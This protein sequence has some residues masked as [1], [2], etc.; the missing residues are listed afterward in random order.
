MATWIE[1]LK[2]WNAKKGGKYMIPKKGSAEYDEVRALMGGSD[3]VIMPKKEYES[4]HKRLI[5]IL[6]KG[7]ERERAAE[8]G[9][10]MREVAER[11]PKKFIADVVAHMKKGAMTK[12]AARHGMKPL[13]YAK[14]VVEEPEKHTL[15]TRRRAQFLVNIQRKKKAPKARHEESESDEE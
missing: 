4:E 8:A 7:S 9:R 15:T 13:E 1:A 10:Q 12:A 3:K 5:E 14:E 2:A 11:D 6:K